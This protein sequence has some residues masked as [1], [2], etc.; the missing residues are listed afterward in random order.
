MY[1]SKSRFNFQLN[2]EGVEKLE[3]LVDEG[4]EVVSSGGS[5]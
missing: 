3:G 4:E 1:N 2:D 5:T